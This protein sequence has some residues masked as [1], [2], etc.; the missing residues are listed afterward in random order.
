M[1]R[2]IVLLV[3]AAALLMS[4]AA[5][6]SE[7]S[8]LLY[9]RGL[10]DFHA[11]RYTEALRLF[12]QAVQADPNDPYALYY[13]GVT[14]GRLGDYDGAVS[15]LSGALARKN[16]LEQARLELGVALVQVGKYHEAE[17]WLMQAQKVADTDAQASLFLGIAQLRLGQT[18]E[19]R[20][21]FARAASLDSTLQLAARY[22]TGVADYR[23]GRWADAQEHFNYVVATNP[24]SDMG[25]E[26]AAFLLDMRYGR[27]SRYQL[28]GAV[29][30]SY[31]SNVVLAA[32]GQPLPFG[33]SRQSDG[34]ANISVG[35]KYA[36]WQ[37]PKA[38]FLVGYDFYQSLYFNLTD[39]NLMDNAP[40]AQML[41]DVGPVQVGLLGRYDYELLHLESFLQEVNALP[42]VT[43]PEGNFGNTQVYFRFRWQ[44]FFDNARINGQPVFFSLLTGN[45]YAPGIRQFVYLGS[46][47]RYV[48][49]GYRYDNQVPQ[50]PDLASQAFGYEGNQ[51]EIGIGWLFPY[52][53]S[54]E[55]ANAYH[56]E[57]YGNASKLQVSGT[58]SNEPPVVVGPRRHD[59]DNRPT[60]ILRKQLNTYL[61]VVGAYYGTFNDSNKPAFQYT[62][63]IGSIALEARFP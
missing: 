19:A 27:G 56:H 8:K 58:P 31:D 48:F 28:Y 51:V 53:I 6:A 9:S 40:S 22:Y 17:T 46:Q 29:G 39:F 25:R 41:A 54:V 23:D 11:G 21:N 59:N 24:S 42:W 13:R 55:V 49:A 18:D 3:S 30:F 14:R 63:Q 20:A 2:L 50:S 45:N 15:D 60:V 44:D 52:E 43:V 1:P 37:S 61:A 4:T 16:D 36:L 12:D 10:V 34:S 5:V 26:A 57:Q 33:I 38:Q 32:G 47:D 35:G 7:Q 62:R